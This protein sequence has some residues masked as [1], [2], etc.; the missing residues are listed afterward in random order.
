MNVSDD[1]ALKYIKIFTQLSFDEISQLI[2]EHN[3]ALTK[4]S[5]RVCLPGV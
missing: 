5:F 3:L 4:E 1:D 2:E